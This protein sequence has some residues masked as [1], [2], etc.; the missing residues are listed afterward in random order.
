MEEGQLLLENSH[1]GAGFRRLFSKNATA[2]YSGCL[3]ALIAVE[4]LTFKLMVD[5][6]AP[7]R[8]VLAQAVAACYAVAV[9]VVVLR[10][11]NRAGERGSMQGFPV[12][13]LAMMAVLDML[14]LVPMIVAAADVAPTLTVLLLQCSA[15]FC[16]AVSG[17]FCSRRRYPRKSVLGAAVIFLGACVAIYLPI[18]RL[19]NAR[20]TLHD[21]ARSHEYDPVHLRGDSGDYAIVEAGYNTILYVLAC[22]P[23]AVSTVYKQYALEQHGRP[24]DAHQLSLGVT[25]F[26]VVFIALAAPAAYQLQVLGRHGDGNAHVGQALRDGWRCLVLMRDVVDIDGY[27]VDAECWGGL[28]LV[29]SYVVATL[30][31]N[32]LVQKVVDQAES[33]SVY[34]RAMAFSVPTAFVVL[35]FYNEAEWLHDSFNVFTVSGLIVIMIGLRLYHSVP[36]PE[37]PRDSFDPPS[38][39]DGKRYG[40]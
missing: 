18:S 4:R 39:P 16:L 27:P 20:A 28:P 26:E 10:R 24:V 17:G 12:W 31:V 38:P 32:T 9:G 13:R 7:F 35:C 21:D 15:P 8:F 29:F 37:D 3:M 14:H 34:H 30:L 40:G 33:A 22:L 6:M 1:P 36:E 25:A 19:I 23:A 11:V 2:I 5:R